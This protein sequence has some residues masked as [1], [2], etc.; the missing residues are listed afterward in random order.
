MPTTFSQRT[1]RPTERE[2]R[3]LHLLGAGRVAVRLFNIVCF[4]FDLLL[5]EIWAC[6]TTVSM[7]SAAWAL[8]CS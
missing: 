1:L 8:A 7:A 4:I 2:A 3:L 5:L 6:L